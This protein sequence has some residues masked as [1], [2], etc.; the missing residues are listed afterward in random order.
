MV[1]MS[2]I[3]RKIPESHVTVH[4]IIIWQTRTHNLVNNLRWS[5]LQKQRLLAVAY[6]LIY[7]QPFFSTQLPFGIQV[8]LGSCLLYISIIMLT[9]AVSIFT[10]FVP[11][12]RPGYIHLVSM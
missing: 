8:L 7:K 4:R 10:I 3:S 1:R 2:T 6:T 9:E 11:M 12:S 5:F